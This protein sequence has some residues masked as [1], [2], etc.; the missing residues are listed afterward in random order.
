[1]TLTVRQTANIAE[2]IEGNKLYQTNA[3]K[4]FALLVRQAEVRQTIFYSSFA[5]A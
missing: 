4:A 1:M 3:R 5:E 2:P